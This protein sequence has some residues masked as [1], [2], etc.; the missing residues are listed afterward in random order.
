MKSKVRSVRFQSDRNLEVLYF[1]LRLRRATGWLWS[2]SRWS[3]TPRGPRAVVESRKCPPQASLGAV[4]SHFTVKF[5]IGR[6]ISQVKTEIGEFFPRLRRAVKSSGL[7]AACLISEWGGEIGGQKCLRIS[8][9]RFL[10]LELLLYS[11]H[12][13]HKILVGMRYTDN[14]GKA[15]IDTG[16]TSF[17]S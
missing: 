5:Q 9:S 3:G 1:S 10:R 4:S 12:S 14:N 17:N 15:F 7:L 2:H 8:V 11:V 13:S 6:L 16:R